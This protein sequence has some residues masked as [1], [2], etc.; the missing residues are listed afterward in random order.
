MEWHAKKRW[1]QYV[2]DNPKIIGKNE[3]PVSTCSIF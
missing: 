3:V 1:G 2:K